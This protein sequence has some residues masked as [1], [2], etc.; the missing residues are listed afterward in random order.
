MKKK[1]SYRDK[2]L[3][4]SKIYNVK[5][6]QEYIKRRKNLT[7]GQIELIL[8]KNK[9]IIP[10]DFN[11]SFFK[12]NISKPFA[13]VTKQIDNLKDNSSKK[14]S[15][16]SRKIFYFKEDS[17]RSVSNLFYNSWKSIVSIKSGISDFFFKSMQIIWRTT[18]NAGLGFLNMIPKLGK[19]YYSFFS[20]FF[21][22]L[23]NGIY[24]QQINKGRTGKAILSF[25][26]V[27]G[28]TT[29]VISGISTFKSLNIFE[30]NEVTREVIKKEK[31]IKEPKKEVKK[32]D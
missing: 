24:N 14:V 10:K 8:R 29:I 6:I 25:F 23:F 7:S 9:I 31:I 32:T 13:R 15:K 1:L 2:L 22:D 17:S 18:G 28:V 20:N 16:V 26:I 30:K 19:T 12:E 11:N 5:E 3:E 21:I 4:L 27:V